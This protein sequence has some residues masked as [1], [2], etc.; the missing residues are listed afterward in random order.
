MAPQTPKD[1]YSSFYIL[2]K[3]FHYVGI[4]PFVFDPKRGIFRTQKKH[5]FI[6]LVILLFMILLQTYL[7]TFCF[8]LSPS[9]SSLQLM[10]NLDSSIMYTLLCIY[11][12]CI[13][14]KII[15]LL[16]KFSDFDKNVKFKYIRTNRLTKYFILNSIFIAV[17]ITTN[18]IL[19]LDAQM[20]LNAICLISIYNSNFSNAL[21]RITFVF[22]LSEI[23]MRADFFQ[24]NLHK[25][26]VFLS[27]VVDLKQLCKIVNSIFNFPLV[28]NFGL[29]FVFLTS[30][31]FFFVTVELNT[32]TFSVFVITCCWLVLAFCEMMLI[33]QP[34]Q[35][36]CDKI[37]E[38][39]AKIEVLSSQER[40]FKKNERFNLHGYLN[41][42]KFVIAG[43]LP[44]DYSLMFAMLGASITYVIYL[45]QFNSL[46]T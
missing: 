45:L 29:L 6:G 24:N 23:K 32:K 8:P 39:N 33:I 43:F 7:V 30:D 3:F 21:V 31:L 37:R 4:L 14:P 27:D 9:T 11:C 38:T 26:G 1:V 17:H 34:A 20:P 2:Y 15:N 28:R 18:L 35:D 22:F 40:K 5:K 36:L 42:V 44:L 12:N 19:N 25:N 10:V 41:D 16:K 13:N 46:Y